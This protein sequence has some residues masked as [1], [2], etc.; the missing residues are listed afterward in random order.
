MGD[1]QPLIS[2][3]PISAIVDPAGNQ[4]GIRAF[5]THLKLI[6]NG[7]RALTRARLKYILIGDA[8]GRAS[9]ITL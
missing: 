8:P 6:S 3:S 4:I 5:K 9:R 2:A 7:R 1:I